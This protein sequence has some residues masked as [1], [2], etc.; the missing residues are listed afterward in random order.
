MSSPSS[1]WSCGTDGGGLV[2]QREGGYV[3]RVAWMNVLLVALL[4]PACSAPEAPGPWVD[5]TADDRW[6]VDSGTPRLPAWSAQGV[7]DQV[8]LAVAKGIPTPQRVLSDYLDLLAHGDE[9]CPGNY[10]EEGFVVLGGCDSADGYHFTGAAGVVREDQRSGEGEGWTGQLRISSAPADYVITR[11]DQSR[12]IAGGTFFLEFRAQAERQEWAARI[13]GTFEDEAAE[14]WLG[15]AFSGM[16]NID[17]TEDPG[18]IRQRISGSLS[19]GGVAIDMQDVELQPSLCPD[20]FVGGTFRVRQEDATWSQLSLPKACG[21]CG[22]VQW[23]GGESL[24]SGC[25][26]PKPWIDHISAIRAW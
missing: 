20:G 25:I 3:L 11:P 24:G 21:A 1:G 5:A 15:A 18:G 17:G 6:P 22:E 13:G 26:D 16:L 4:L 9:S 12:L 7:A 2:A 14:D 10:F 19:V 23:E 8:D